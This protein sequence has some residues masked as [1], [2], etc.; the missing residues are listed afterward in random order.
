VSYSL[1]HDVTTA[2]FDV[3]VV[4]RSFDVPVLVDFWAPWCGPCKTL[5][6]V[7]ERVAAAAAGRFE[8]VKVDTEAEPGL[9]T[10]FE[11]RGIPHVKLF[12]AGRERARFVGALSGAEVEGFLAEH[13]ATPAT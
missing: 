8:L 4:E 6:P 2:S 11:I 3:D 12:V 7:L 1:A 9:A 5:G 13:L 10:R